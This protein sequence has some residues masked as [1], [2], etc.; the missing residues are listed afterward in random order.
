MIAFQGIV[1]LKIFSAILQRN[2][3]YEVKPPDKSGF[4]WRN[5]VAD[6]ASADDA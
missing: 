6:S 4:Q 3:F 5:H 1:R 2:Y